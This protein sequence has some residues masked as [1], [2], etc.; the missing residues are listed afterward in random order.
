MRAI[1]TQRFLSF[2]VPS[3]TFTAMTI[4][5]DQVAKDAAY[6]HEP[7]VLPPAVV[8]LVCSGPFE[9]HFPFI[10]YHTAKGKYFE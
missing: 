10:S 4:G 6:I 2:N 9:K 1:R 8:L 7:P 3:E 5:G